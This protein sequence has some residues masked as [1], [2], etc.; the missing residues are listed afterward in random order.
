MLL[1]MAKHGAAVLLSPVSEAS[2]ELV[3]DR[4]R[5]H[6]GEMNREKL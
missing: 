6:Q 1:A 2:A 3:Q 4:Q 5:T